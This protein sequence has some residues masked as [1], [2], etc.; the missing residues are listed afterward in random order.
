[1]SSI[2]GQVFIW[3]TLVNRTFPALQNPWNSENILFVLLI[4]YSK[5]EKNA[6]NKEFALSWSYLKLEIIL[7][8]QYLRYLYY[9]RH[10]K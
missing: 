1:M 2:I 3:G 7:Y 8:L 10:L 4:S 5:N 9:I 6:Y